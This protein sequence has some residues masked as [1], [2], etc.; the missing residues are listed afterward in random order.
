MKLAQFITQTSL[1]SIDSV[2]SSHCLGKAASIIKDPM[3]PGNTLFHLLPSEKRYESLKTYTNR[4][5]KS[6]L[7]AAIWLLNV[8]S[9]IKLIFLFTLSTTIFCTLSFLSPHV[10]YEWYVL[11]ATAPKKQYQYFSVYPM[12]VTIIN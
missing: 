6:F 10:L 5:K 3:H 11:S 8:P 7:L 9:H 1:P 4:V 2:Y 12:H